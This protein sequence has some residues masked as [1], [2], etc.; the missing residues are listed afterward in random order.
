MAGS[1]RSGSSTEITA[2]QQ[3]TQKM[4]CKGFWSASVRKQFCSSLPS[5]L[6]GYTAPVQK[7]TG[8]F[9]EKMLQITVTARNDNNRGCSFP[10]IASQPFLLPLILTPWFWSPLLPF[11]PIWVPSYALLLIAL[12]SECS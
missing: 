9:H 5:T 11:Y 4:F 3:K 7:D 1:Q 12:S 8:S 10:L 2:I 6:L